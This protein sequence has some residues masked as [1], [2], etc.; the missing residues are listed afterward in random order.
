MKKTILIF[1][2]LSIAASSFA[3]SGLNARSMGMAGAYNSL[4]LGSE[5]SRWNPANLGLPF[6]HE[7]AQMASEHPFWPRSPKMS[8][9]FAKFAVSLGN[10]SLNL[11]LYNK[12]FSKSYFDANEYWDAAAKNDIIGAFDDDLQGFLNLQATAFAVSYMRF[13]FAVNTF[14]YTKVR[15]PQDFVT[16]PL[17]GLGAAPLPIENMEGEA[18]AATEFAF[19]TSK[20][21]YEWDYFDYF[22]LGATFKYFLGHEYATL[23]RADGTILS[24]QDSIAVNGDYRLLVAFPFDDRGKGGDGVG[25]D[26]G[27]AAIMGEKL[28]LGLTLSNIVGSINFGEVEEQIG[29]I[30]LNEPGVSQDELDNFGDYID[31]VMVQTE[32]TYIS[33]DI[34]RYAMPKV[35]TLSANYRV[36]PWIIVE[37][38]YQQGLNNTAGGTTTPRLAIGTE[39]GYLKFLPWRFGLAFGGLQGTTIAT[40][41]GLKLGPFQMDFAVAGQRG[42]FNGSKGVNF[43]IAPRLTF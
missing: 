33:P 17:K 39:I 28:V 24:N 10:N 36:K 14:S 41:F 34:I 21:L 13:A 2:M 22:S 3:Q 18:I 27:A 43:A 37:A 40:G 26:L 30:A 15:L 20:V 19:S 7:F 6:Q 12:Y 29:T 25:L 16:I 11:D 4:A 23:D 42:L 1:A 31:S 9:D 8:I 35:L 32:E 38:D 5:V